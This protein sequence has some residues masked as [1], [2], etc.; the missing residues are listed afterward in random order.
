MFNIDKELKYKNEIPKKN[1]IKVIYEN[2]MSN[3]AK[4]DE[5]VLKN[6]IK[7]RTKCTN[8]NDMINMIIYYKWTKTKDHIIKN[9]LTSS[10]F[11]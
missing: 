4:L 10:L 1:K 8:A 3:N 9:S 5:K 2:Q 7:Q 6:I 11:L